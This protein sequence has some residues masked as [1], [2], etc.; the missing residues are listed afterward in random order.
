VPFS[1]RPR[2]ANRSWP[3]GVHKEQRIRRLPRRDGC[4]PREPDNVLVHGTSAAGLL[5][6]TRRSAVGTLRIRTFGA[7][8]P[9]SVSKTG[10]VLAVCA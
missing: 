8:S 7:G 1:R 9:V 5:R 4:L 3:R 6:T 10:R 2:V